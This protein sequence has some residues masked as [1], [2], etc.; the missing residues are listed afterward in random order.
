MVSNRENKKEDTEEK[1][2]KK[3]I[4]GAPKN[5]VLPVLL[6]LLRDWNAHGYELMQKLIHFGFHSIDQGNFYR[7]LRQLEKDELVTSEWDTSS[8]GPAKRIYSITEAGEQY[9]QLWAD[10]MGQY[11]KMLDQFFNLYS[12]FFQPPGFPTTKDKK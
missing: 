12:Q 7:I 9:L 2:G 11:Q 4:V 10:S 3:N 6:L 5:F 1:E 8:S